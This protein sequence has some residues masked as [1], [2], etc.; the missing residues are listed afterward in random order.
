MRNARLLLRLALFGLWT[1]PLFTA[2]LLGA[3]FAILGGRLTRWRARIQQV[4]SRGLCRIL[5]VRVTVEGEV[6]RRSFFLV[7]NHVS[8]LDILVLGGLAPCSF[9]AKSELR[10]WPVLGF[11]A[12]AMGTVF[13]ERQ[14]KRALGELNRVLAA[15]MARGDSLV[16]FPEGTSTSGASV[17][18]FRPALLQPA[19]VLGLPVRYAA[20][21][22]ATAPG[23]RPASEVVCWWGDMT[24]V[25]HLL[26]LL[27]LAR[28][29]AEVRLGAEPVL[30]SDRKVLAARLHAAV[31]SCFEAGR[32]ERAACAPRAG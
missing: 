4:W 29:E 13:V 32:E 12:R 31:A 9:V 26:E 11:L 30:A 28:I 10:G 7:S 19:A 20:V 17:L 27:R 15:R 14:N 25:G 18:P 1:L 22:Y 16:L 8:Y 2:W 24:F 5:G 3:P 21:R 23:E 6:P